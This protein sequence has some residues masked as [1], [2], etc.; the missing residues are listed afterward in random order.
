M[1]QQMRRI[2][3]QENPSNGRQGRVEKMYSSS[4]LPFFIARSKRKLQR[5]LTLHGKG[6]V[7]IF[8][9][10]ALM[11]AK[12]QRKRYFVLQVKCL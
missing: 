11:E 12:I 10:N 4:K 1:R 5:L 9:K 6:E 3:F 7:L 8:K 2:K